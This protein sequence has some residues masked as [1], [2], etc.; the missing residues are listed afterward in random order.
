MN[1]THLCLSEVEYRAIT[2]LQEWEIHRQSISL[3]TVYNRVCVSLFP[4][5]HTC[6]N[7]IQGLTH[8][9]QVLHL[10]AIAR[11]IY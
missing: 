4:P 8:A 2:Y 1:G 3:I 9:I 6:R 11:T 5:A 10:C 7:L